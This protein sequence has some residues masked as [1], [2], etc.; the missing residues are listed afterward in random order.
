MLVVRSLKIGSG[1]FFFFCEMLVAIV[2][3]EIHLLDL[4]HERITRVSTCALVI[5]SLLCH[6][7]K[8]VKEILLVNAVITDCLLDAYSIFKCID[9][10]DKVLKAFLIVLAAEAECS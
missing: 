9:S 7:V 10:V 2:S 3:V 1:G 6:C 5:E 8:T 4:T